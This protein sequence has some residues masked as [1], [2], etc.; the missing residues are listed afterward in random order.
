MI[1]EQ[2]SRVTRDES[3]TKGLTTSKGVPLRFPATSFINMKRETRTKKNETNIAPSAT[4][5]VP[6]NNDEDDSEDLLSRMEFNDII[7]GRRRRGSSSNAASPSSSRKSS[8]SSSPSSS[9]PISQSSSTTTSRGSTPSERNVPAKETLQLLGDV[10][11][12]LLNICTNTASTPSNSGNSRK[13]RNSEL[14]SAAGP[15]ENGKDEENG[16]ESEEVQSGTNGNS[17]LWKVSSSD[18]KVEVAL[19]APASWSSSIYCVTSPTL[20]NVSMNEYLVKFESQLA[21][22]YSLNEAA[23]ERMEWWIDAGWKLVVEV[24]RG[25]DEELERIGAMM[26]C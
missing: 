22:R 20:H 16:S 5:R 23:L 18:L 19:N 12:A 13:G 1:H 6:F 7:G 10:R 25:D 15:C 24:E 14:S 26:V 9:R 3:G 11:S 21:P 4:S 2:S 17:H 8:R